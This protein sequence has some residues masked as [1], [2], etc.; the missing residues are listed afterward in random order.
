MEQNDASWAVVFHPDFVDEFR[1]LDR[2]VKKKLG[3]LLDLL[4]GSGPSLGRPQADALVGSKHPNMKELRM[5]TADD[6]YRF[7][8]AFDPKQKA[9]ILC[10]GG[11]GGGS[12]DKFYRALVVKA[13]GRFDSW[14]ER[15][16]R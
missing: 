12:Q 6:W 1:D 15:I 13:D 16:D 14:L 4:R 9:V 7:A 2:P 10:G 11:K 5:S 3:E 8:F